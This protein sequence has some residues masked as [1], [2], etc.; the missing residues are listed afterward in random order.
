MSAQEETPKANTTKSAKAA[1]KPVLAR[2]DLIRSIV[3]CW[4]TDPEDRVTQNIQVLRDAQLDFEHPEDGE[5]WAFVDQFARDHG[6]APELQTVDRALLASNQVGAADRLR[7]ISA[8]PLK[9]GGDFVKD[10]E[11]VRE[12]WRIKVLAQTMRDQKI[13]LTSGLEVGHG[14]NKQV[15]RGAQQAAEHAIELL[16][17]IASPPSPK[18]LAGKVLA[19][20]DDFLT[21]YQER[22]R[23]PN[24]SFGQWTG[25]KQLD[26]SLG[27][28]RD[29][30]LWVH[31]AFAGHLKTTF[32]LNWAYN[33]AIFF[34]WDVLYFSLEMPYRQ[35]R[36]WIVAMHSF[37]EKFRDSRIALGLQL[38]GGVDVGLDYKRI[39]DAHEMSEAEDRFLR[40]NVVPDLKNPANGYGEI[41]VEVA[42]PSKPDITVEGLRSRAETIYQK[43]PFSMMFVDHASLL[44][45]RNKYA[46]TT[47][48]LN[49]AMRDLKQTAINFRRG[50]GLPVV[51]LFQINREGLKEAQKRKEKGQLPTYDLHNLAYANEAER[52]A[53][54]VTASY[55]DK[56]L[57]NRGRALFTNLKSRDNAPFD[58]CVT[59]VVW[60]CRRIG[61]C[62]ESPQADYATQASTKNINDS[63]DALCAMAA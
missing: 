57:A 61:T 41:H 14:R 19:E 45:A 56:E 34:H 38:P 43:S 52:S 21:E 35:V 12:D 63:L 50:K 49:E 17:P 37:H 29:G 36:R 39:R 53:D 31:A 16:G 46:N 26:E 48:R 7:M 24:S 3:R 27:G 62:T 33:Q 22:R 2:A 28:A 42:D 10:I 15:L 5:I 1:P 8:H 13:I 20:A 4:H 25:I 40:E 54:V 44:G 6:H 23:N 60:P 18:G 11:T 55:L 47:D 51:A 9:W 30:E 32:A 59:E 58:P